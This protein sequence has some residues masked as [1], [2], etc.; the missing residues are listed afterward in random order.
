MSDVES[1]VVRLQALR[2][3]GLHVVVDD[4]GA[5]YSSL[6]HLGCF[7]MDFLNIDRSF[8]LKLGA[9]P[10]DT[11]IVSAMI[12]LAHAL[13]LGVTA[14]QLAR[15]RALGCDMAQGYYLWEPLSS[16]EMSAFLSLRS[17]GV[18]SGG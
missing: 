18:G 8:T 11:A 12:N 16:A 13:G 2:N 9:K 5:A 15:L 7:P 4:F 6:S 14:D 1:S 10:E 17:R 3:L